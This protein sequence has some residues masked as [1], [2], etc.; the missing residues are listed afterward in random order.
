MLSTSSW[1]S[2]SCPRAEHLAYPMRMSA[3]GRPGSIGA[4][5]GVP[6]AH[7]RPGP[8]SAASDLSVGEGC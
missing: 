1:E 8:R 5:G 7:G 2:S 6:D 4:D 3:L